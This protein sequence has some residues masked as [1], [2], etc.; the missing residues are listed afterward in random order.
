M[1]TMR[2]YLAKG[3]SCIRL[4]K[5]YSRNPRLDF[6][7]AVLQ[8]ISFKEGN[9]SLYMLPMALTAIKQRRRHL[10]PNTLLKSLPQAEENRYTVVDCAL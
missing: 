1:K 7:Q 6:N 9:I 2:V 3:E 4:A 8:A 5:G 10:L